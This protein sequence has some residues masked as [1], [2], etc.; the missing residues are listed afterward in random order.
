MK[1]AFSSPVFRST[2]LNNQLIDWVVQGQAANRE[3]FKKPAYI[4]IKGD[5]NADV[6]TVQQVIKLHAG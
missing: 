1:L 3:L 6:P 5:G 2:R 4:A